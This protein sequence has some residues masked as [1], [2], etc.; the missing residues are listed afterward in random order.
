MVRG[1]NSAPLP[2]LKYVICSKTGAK[3]AIMPEPS[4][5]SAPP[6]PDAAPPL[7]PLT[8]LQMWIVALGVVAMGVGMTINFVVVAP[9]T[10]DAG[11]TEIEVAGI[12]TLSALFFAL[13]TP[14]WG[15]WADRFGRKR[16]MVASLA[17]AGLTNAG[18]ALALDQALAGTL[19]GLNAVLSLGL[20]RTSFGLLS[21]GVFPAS[22]GMII[23]ATTPKT[24]AAGMGLFGT[25]MSIGSI[26]GPAGAAALAPFGALAP[27]WGSILFSWVCALVLAFALPK[28]RT[29]RPGGLRPQ[30]LKLT[31]KRIRPHMIF[32]LAYFIIVGGIQMT[33]GFLVADRYGLAR[34]DAVQATGLAFGSLALAMII[35]QFGYVQRRYP[36]PKRMLPTGLIFVALG[37][38]VAAVFE[39]FVLMCLGFFI[40]GMG[41][42][43]VVPAANALGS[44]AVS[45]QDQPSAAAVLSSAPPWAFVIGPLLGAQLYQIDPL[46]PLLA[47]AAMMI[48]LFVYATRVTLRSEA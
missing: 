40:V 10:R 37:Y 26:I 38:L 33:L 31:D 14:I 24:R 44:L 3:R 32:L 6:P 39:P 15:R 21:P 7:R 29:R 34:A 12:L 23:E 28:S 41:A 2:D 16:V 30:P 27:L 1:Q 22:M 25:A 45:P 19:L 8:P 17:F 36:D 42:A 43:L 35:V 4:P 48:V 13:M 5:S 47:S 9:L 46:T 11:L 18:F 20:I